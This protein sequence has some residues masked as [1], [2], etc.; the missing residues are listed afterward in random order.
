MQTD[1]FPFQG[2]LGV[3]FWEIKEYTQKT[4]MKYC[5]GNMVNWFILVGLVG[6]MERHW[7]NQKALFA[8]VQELL[9]NT[10]RLEKIIFYNQRFVSNNTNM[11]VDPMSM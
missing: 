11:S 8:G 6:M 9:L 7:F 10:M 1:K 4:H 5:K 2:D 3:S